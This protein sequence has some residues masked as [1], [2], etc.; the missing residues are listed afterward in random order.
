VSQKEGNVKVERTKQTN[1]S[2]QK[3]QKKKPKKKKQNHNSTW[4]FFFI[5][6]ILAVNQI[7]QNN[8]TQR[9]RKKR[10][11]YFVYLSIEARE[12]YQAFFCS[13]LIQHF[14]FLKTVF[15]VALCN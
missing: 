14:F 1:V 11:T 4:F 7:N 5:L 6:F 12:Y 9:V 8:T 13:T 10:E 2:E 15:S 3:N